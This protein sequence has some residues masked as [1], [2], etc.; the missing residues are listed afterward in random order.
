[1]KKSTNILSILLTLIAI[2]IWSTGSWWYYTCRIKNTCDSNLSLAAVTDDKSALTTPKIATLNV[3][4]LTNDSDND[5]ISDK[6]EIALQT[7]PKNNDSD[8]DGILDTDEIGPDL[9]NA[10]DS[11]NDGKIDALDDDDDNDGLPTNIE[12]KIGT[13]PLLK[14]TDEDGIGDLEEL[15]K[16]ELQALDTDNDGIINALDTDDD[17]DGIETTNELL[18]GTNPLL[19]DTDSDGVSDLQEIGDL[20][21]KPLDAD[22]DGIIDALDTE[23]ILDHDGDGLTDFVEKNLGSDSK[24][25]DSDDDGINDNEELGDD[26]N[27]ALDT[28]G[29]G[30]INILDPDDDNDNLDTRFESEIGTNPLSKD[31]DGD[32]LD[33]AK[34]VA[35][36][37]I[38]DLRDT[39]KDG[40][41]DAIDS[42]DDNDG[43]AT[44]IEL[45]N[46]SN[47]LI[48][49]TEQTVVDTDTTGKDDK[50][51]SD[52]TGTNINDKTI[53]TS[54]SEFT[55]QQLGENSSNS[56]K[57][58]NL[59]WP[60]ATETPQETSEISNYLEQVI[61]WL[62]SNK[63]NTIS[64][65]GHT[66]EYSSQQENLAMGI[67][68]VMMVRE[69]LI[70]KGARYQQID[71]ASRGASEPIA[72]SNTEE[73]KLKN[74]R[75]EILPLD[76]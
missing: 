39:D 23:E 37:D 17:A 20:L 24:N 16:N 31:T 13:S 38:N 56:F 41:I 35:G 15:G 54:T 53:K 22:K 21:D 18:L 51:T 49:D 25:I 19:A 36:G 58:A 76:L 29:D 10:L 62:R 40:K 4:E 14:D 70:E 6:D 12:V 30:I 9:K 42:D 28:D 5:G 61:H 34:E 32:G 7:D 50:T 66:D 74:R 65:V 59:Y 27:A 71:F 55:L 3:S 46:G 47:P 33:D 68:Q 11:D 48:K 67:K 72:D 45:K 57:T 75:V 1:M 69:L 44:L 52:S 26:L 2:S 60:E 8:Q 63:R 73:G 43:I 64:L